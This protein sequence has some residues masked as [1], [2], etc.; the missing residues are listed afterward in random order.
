MLLRPLHTGCKI[1]DMIRETECRRETFR[2]P[3][4]VLPW[5]ILTTFVALLFVLTPTMLCAMPMTSMNM[6]EH[7]CCKHMR[8]A[9]D[10]SRANM[11]SCCATIPTDTGLVLP[12]LMKNPVGSS[13]IQAEVATFNPFQASPVFSPLIETHTHGSPP[14]PDS[15]Y[16]QILRI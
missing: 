2:V 7:E 15:A 10:C 6:A 13:P 12:E 14:Q 11:T 16:L 3:D 1:S 4:R 5:R 9:D 8:S